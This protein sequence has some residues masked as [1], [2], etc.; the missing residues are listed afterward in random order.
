M[1]WFIIP[2]KHNFTYHIHIY[3]YDSYHIVGQIKIHIP[4]YP[5]ISPF[6]VVNH[7]DER[8]GVLNQIQIPRYPVP[9]WKAGVEAGGSEAAGMVVL[10]I[11]PFLVVHPT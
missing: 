5:I 8:W 7:H 4:L 9:L 1:G 10:T 6:S 11:K 3:I 2:S